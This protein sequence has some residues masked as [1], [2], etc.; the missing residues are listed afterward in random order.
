MPHLTPGDRA[1]YQADLGRVLRDIRKLDRE[2]QDRA[3]A[4][5]RTLQSQVME[6]LAGGVSQ[7][8]YT[9]TLA[10]LGDLLGTFATA[11]GRDLTG[12]M[13][14][15]WNLGETLAAIGVE[16]V[17]GATVELLTVL[18]QTTPDLVG[19]LTTEI[20]RR[21]QSEISAI[22]SGARTQSDAIRNIGRDLTSPNHFR[23]VAARARAIMQTEAGRAQALATHAT[24]LQM[25]TAI[26]GLRK[27]W[28]NA[29]L[30]GSRTSHLETEARYAEGGSVGPIPVEDSFSVG[31]FQAM[32]PRS[33]ELPARHVVHCKCVVV[34]VLPPAPETV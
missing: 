32:Y 14:E 18:T 31:G 8:G 21:I 13:G 3:I 17:P 15:G 29:H 27:R 12:L 7:A 10:S 20:R 24:Q 33:P 16:I 4:L 25:T 1:Q 9:R 5:V 6:L 28:L 2:A 26:P 34:T 11:Y 22:A 23:T 30:Q 19:G